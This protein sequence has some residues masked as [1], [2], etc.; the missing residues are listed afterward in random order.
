MTCDILELFAKRHSFYEINNQLPIQAS[1][2]ISLI[3]KSLQLYPSPYNSQSARIIALMGDKHLAFWE[4][5]KQELLKSATQDKFD[6]INKRI[7]SFAKGFGTLL[8]FIETDIV[9]KQE[10]QMPL[11]AIN[12]KNWAYQSNAILQFMIWSAL[13]D[14]NIGA[15]LQHYNPL[16]NNA[17]YK[18]FD[19]PK[20]WEL[21]AQMPFGGIDV[22]PPPHIVSDLKD[23]LI[24]L[25]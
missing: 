6:G 2:M 12:F 25:D 19:L 8:Y 24:V 13:A 4:L 1:E 11:Y 3:K 22:T 16:I 20:T 14:Y 15:S 9:Q 23:K 17:V 18:T 10:Q 5:V 7:S 21:T